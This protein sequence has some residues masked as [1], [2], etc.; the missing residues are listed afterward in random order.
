MTS[1][2][3]LY[4]FSVEFREKENEWRQQQEQLSIEWEEENFSEA[5]IQSK[6]DSLQ[7]KQKMAVEEEDYEVAE[8][9]DEEIQTLMEKKEGFKYCHP[10]FSIKVKWR[11][12]TISKLMISQWE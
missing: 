5:D 10:I 9:I 2:F 12:F 7:L 6:I 4:L 1:T 11:F 3:V 8:V